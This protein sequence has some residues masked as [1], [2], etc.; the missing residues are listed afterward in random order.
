M[1]TDMEAVSGTS[2]DAVGCCDD[3][4]VRE[5]GCSADAAVASCNA[6]VDS[7]QECVLIGLDCCATD[8][9]WLWCQRGVHPPTAFSH[10]LFLRCG[11]ARGD[12][13]GGSVAEDRPTRSLPVHAHGRRTEDK[14]PPKN[15]DMAV[16]SILTF[17][18]GARSAYQY[19]LKDGDLAVRRS[20]QQA[21][22]DSRCNG[23]HLRRAL[24]ARR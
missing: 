17:H 9:P 1:H 18:L 24:C 11:D 8:D 7:S 22:L 10:S 4:L 19:R 15:C 6:V 16:V 21:Q 20:E 14:L 3:P 23:W 5:H 2:L 13:R 12:R